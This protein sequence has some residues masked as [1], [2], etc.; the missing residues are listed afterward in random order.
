MNYDIKKAIGEAR[1][2]DFANNLFIE[3]SKFAGGE[4]HDIL[5]LLTWR[6]NALDSGGPKDIKEAN[7][8]E[9]LLRAFI[10]RKKL[11]TLANLKKMKEE[12]GL[13]D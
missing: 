6:R 2:D 7:K 5:N 3:I 12:F 1:L 9:K 10:V 13:P 4:C 11:G 8:I